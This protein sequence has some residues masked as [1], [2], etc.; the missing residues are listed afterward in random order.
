VRGVDRDGEKLF[1]N[2]Q[3]RQV[4]LRLAH[5]KSVKNEPPRI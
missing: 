5:G 4:I 3:L 1:I 2:S